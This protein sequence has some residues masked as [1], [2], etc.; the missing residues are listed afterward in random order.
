MNNNDNKKPRKA[1]ETNIQLEEE[2]LWDLEDDWDNDVAAGATEENQGAT[3]E[4]QRPTGASGAAEETESAAAAAKP[5]I[6]PDSGGK[7]AITGETSSPTKTAEPAP[8]TAPETEPAPTEEAEA[9]KETTKHDS[10]VPKKTPLSMTEKIALSALAAILIGLAIW[11]YSF[12]YQKNFL[13][14]ESSLKLPAQGQYATVSKFS[15]FWTSAGKSAGIRLGVAVVPA[16]SITLDE[17]ST[18]GALRVFFRNAD[19]DRIGDPIT[20]SFQNGKFTAPN[21]PHISLSDDGSTANISSSDGFSLEGDFHAYQMDE[22]LAWKVHVL[23]AESAAAKGTSYKE[24]FSTK[25]EPTRQ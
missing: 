8:E 12:L 11:G 2:N 22:S 4:N 10:S 9:G 5:T 19:N 16:A 18:S 15:S 6:K 7:T 17:S 3:E 23:E 25:M 1:H 13:E 24:L 21:S 14:K 20:L